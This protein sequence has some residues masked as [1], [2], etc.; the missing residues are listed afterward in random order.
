MGFSFD[1]QLKFKAKIAGLARQP[2]D[3]LWLISKKV[4]KETICA[5]LG[6]CVCL[7]AVFLLLVVV[8]DGAVLR[9]KEIK[10]AFSPWAPVSMVNSVDE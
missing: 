1:E 5:A 2:S 4:T 7:D 9:G 6:I 10:G 8:V 3:F